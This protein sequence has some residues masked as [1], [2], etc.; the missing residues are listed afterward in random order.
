[1]KKVNE[2]YVTKDYDKFVFMN[3]NRN[4]N[5][6]HLKRMAESL[7][8]KQLPIPIIVK[9]VEGGKY[10]I[11]EG[12]HRFTVCREHELPVYF[13]VIDDLE[14]EDA[15]RINTT[16]KKWSAE[17]YFQH[18]KALGY[19][20][21]MLLDMFMQ[22]TGLSLHNARTF[23]ESVSAKG[24]KQQKD[25]IN[26][27]FRVENYDYS[28]EMYYRHLDYSEIPAFAKA[29]CKLA[30]M[31]IMLHPKYDHD[32]MKLKLSQAGYMIT[33]RVTLSD[34]LAIFT[35]VYNYNASKQSRVY[36]NLD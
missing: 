23:L 33:N 1:M 13:T 22:V 5:S 29:N 4:V 8:R 28:L 27:L 2:I 24:V 25:F 3:G 16:M 26:G 18:Y 21:Y 35:E 11:F 36:F 15:I 7:L 31:K 34:Y 20:H 30:I 32:R 17:D 19:E 6:L 14:L 10:Q 12:Q 9:T